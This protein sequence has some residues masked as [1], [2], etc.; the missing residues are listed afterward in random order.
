MHIA[1]HV[2]RLFTLLPLARAAPGARPL[3]L[4]LTS[5]ERAVP[6]LRRLAML[7][8]AVLLV[9]SIT[10]AQLL[11]GRGARCADAS[12]PADG[13]GCTGVFVDTT[14]LALLRAPLTPVLHFEDVPSAALTLF[15]LATLDD[16]P[17]LVRPFA[18]ADAAILLLFGVWLALAALL[19][20]NLVTAAV[21][22][23]YLRVSLVRGVLQCVSAQ[24]PS[25][26][27]VPLARAGA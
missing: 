11:S 14:G 17:S 13:Q 22:D 24:M 12:L 18:E 21:V 25:V 19:W 9:F 4:V 2:R 16:W 27:T 23:S 8:A 26:L 3:A 1:T 5:L 10:T 6:S 7:A 20:R 15:A